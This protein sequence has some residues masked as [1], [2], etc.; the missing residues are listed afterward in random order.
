MESTD[1]N[2]SAVLLEHRKHAYQIDTIFERI[3]KI[4]TFLKDERIFQ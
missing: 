2:M 3:V 4:E 1:A